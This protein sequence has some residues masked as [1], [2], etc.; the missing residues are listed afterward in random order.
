MPRLPKKGQPDRVLKLVLRKDRVP[1]GK[2]MWLTRTSRMWVKNNHPNPL[3][4]Y[5][6]RAG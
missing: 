5:G 3:S 1:R 2:K 6:E 4:F